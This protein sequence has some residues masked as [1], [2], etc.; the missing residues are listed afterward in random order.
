MN[1]IHRNNLSTRKKSQ[2]IIKNG[3]QEAGETANVI[4]IEKYA[5]N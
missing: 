3:S 4:K 5:T 2:G 1:E